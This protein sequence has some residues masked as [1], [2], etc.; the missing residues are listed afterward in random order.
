MANSFSDIAPKILAR[1]LPTLRENAVFPRLVNTGYS[2]TPMQKGLSV[3]IEVPVAST[4]AAITASN[5]PPSNTDSTPTIVQV[6]ADQWYGAA[7]HLSDKDRQQINDNEQ[8]VPPKIAEAVKAITNNVDAAVAALYKDV[9][10]ASGTAATTPFADT[11]ALKAGWTAGARKFLNT[12]LAPFD[13]RNIV[14][15]VEA[16]ANALSLSEFQAVDKR[17]DAGGI[18]NGEI[19]YKLGAGWFLDQHIASHTSGTLTN[20]SGMLAKVNDA[21]Y[22]AGESTVNIDDTSLSGT[23]VIGDL[24]TVAGDTQVYTVTANATAA[25][26]AIAGMAFTPTSQVAWADDAVITFKASHTA[27]LAFHRDAFALVTAPLESGGM[28]DIMSIQDPVT[29]LILRLEQRRDYKQTTWE[30]D[31]LYGVKTVRP[32]LAARILG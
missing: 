17:G 28:G 30:F 27:N 26:N 10:N 31:I 29:G 18:I 8:F 24:F 15:D 4:A 11:A 7:F 16:E 25:T 20:G 32:E 2:L 14:L 22:T 9:Y 6:S 12:N 19:G 1:A 5:T 21:S 23:V 13:N 3:D